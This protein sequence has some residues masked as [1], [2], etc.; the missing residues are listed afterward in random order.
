MNPSRWLAPRTSW[1]ALSS[2][3]HSCSSFFVCNGR[4]SR[5]TRTTVVS[6]SSATFPSML[7][8]TV[9]MS[10]TFVP[11]PFAP[12]SSPRSACRPISSPRMGKL[13]ESSVRLGDH[14]A[15]S[16]WIERVRRLTE[17]VDVVRIDHFRGLLAGSYLPGTKRHGEAG[18]KRAPGAGVVHGNRS[19]VGAP[20]DRR[21]RSGHH[22][23][24]C[25][26]P[27]AKARFARYEGA[28]IWVRLGS[29]QPHSPHN[30]VSDCVVYTGM[31]DNQTT[32]GW[33]QSCNEVERQQVQTYLGTD[34]SDIAWDFIRLAFES[35]ADLAI[36]PLQDVMRLGDDARMNRPGIAFGTGNGG[37]SPHQL[38]DG[39][40][41]GLRELSVHMDGWIVRKQSRGTIPS[42]TAHRIPR[43]DSSIGMT[44]S[45]SLEMSAVANRHYHVGGHPRVFPLPGGDSMS[46]VG[47]F[48]FVF[49]LPLALCPPG[50]HVAA[51]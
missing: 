24:G 40:A 30:Y 14:G 49:H 9:P 35:V 27:A 25:G 28:A 32:I 16:W 7:L 42:I 4:H 21:R 34:G 44:L 23:P 48:T 51:W 13:G 50:W 6:R 20:A 1:P 36:V 22:H 41:R 11:V 12:R 8:S 2:S 45:T 43:T 19:R 15:S 29:Q 26:R 47:G 10:G 3:T 38:N 17:L 39:L 37:T 5:S 31:H 46:K 33:F 18:G